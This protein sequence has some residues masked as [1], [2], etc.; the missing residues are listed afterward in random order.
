MLIKISLH[1]INCKKYFLTVINLFFK[2]LNTQMVNTI[3]LSY[4]IYICIYMC[5]YIYTFIDECM[6]VSLT[7]ILN[8]HFIRKIIC[9]HS[10]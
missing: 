1:N 3:F 9:L 7:N 2:T 6:Y 8:F 4:V 10:R 5:V